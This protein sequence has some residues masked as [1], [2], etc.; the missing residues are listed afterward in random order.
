MNKITIQDMALAKLKTKVSV[1]DY[2][3]GEMVSRERHE[4]VGGEVF[5]M[6]GPVTVIIEF[7][8]I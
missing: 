3:E 8:S 7:V 6:A 4:Y 1:E 5:A 2:F